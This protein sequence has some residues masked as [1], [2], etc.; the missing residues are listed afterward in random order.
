[1]IG[2]FIWHTPVGDYMVELHWVK[3]EPV[4]LCDDE[5]LEYALNLIHAYDGTNHPD[6]PGYPYWWE[7]LKGKK[8]TVLVTPPREVDPPL[9]G[10]F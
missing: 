9:G 1:M 10:I 7:A 5:H 6:S 3:G 4:W 2:K 8:T